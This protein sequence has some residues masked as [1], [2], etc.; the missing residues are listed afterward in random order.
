[1]VPPD[2]SCPCSELGGEA[3]EA[4]PGFE[5]VWGEGLSALL[6]WRE[7]SGV[8]TGCGRGVRPLHS[9][10]WDSPSENYD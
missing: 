8:R 2:F 9:L 3:N 7:A 1:M 5:G 4:Q 6:A 10:E